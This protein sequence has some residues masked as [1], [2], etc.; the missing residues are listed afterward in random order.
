MRFRKLKK[1][2]RFWLDMSAWEA[3]DLLHSLMEVDEE[4]LSV[5]EKH[6]I[7]Q[8]KPPVRRYLNGTTKPLPGRLSELYEWIDDG[9]MY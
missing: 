5:I 2:P 7:T 4:D 3:C 9:Y 1:K 6:L 8:M